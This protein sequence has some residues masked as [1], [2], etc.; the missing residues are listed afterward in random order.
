[1]KRFAPLVGLSSLLIPLVG[2][3][4]KNPQANPKCAAVP[5]QKIKYE[6]PKD[7]TG[8][9]SAPTIGYVIETDGSVTNVKVV[10]SSGSKAV[11]EVV[12][13]AVKKS[14]YRPLK[15]GCGPIDSKA[16]ITIDFF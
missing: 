1:M 12:L 2:A 10:K 15:P 13:D 9:K 4:Q 6:L 11:D 7:L 14:S 3:Q 16:T 8:Y 5:A